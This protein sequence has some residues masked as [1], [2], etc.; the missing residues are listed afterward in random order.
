MQLT[1]RFLYWLTIMIAVG[2]LARL[3]LRASQSPV[4]AAQGGGLLSFVNSGQALGDVQSTD[5]ALGDLDGDG[6]L[7]AYVAVAGTDVLWLNNGDGVFSADDQ[8][9]SS[10]PGLSAVA[11]GDLDSDGDLDVFVG[12]YGHNEVWLNDGAGGLTDSGQRLGSEGSNGV[13]LGDVDDDG[14]LDAVAANG[15]ASSPANRLWLNDGGAQGGSEG[16]FSDSGQLLGAGWSNGVA[17]GD[18][19][20]DGDLDIYFAR[21]GFDEVWLN[22]GTGQFTADPQPLPSGTSIDVALGDLDGDDDLDVWVATS[23]GASQVWLNDGGA[24]GGSEGN[25]SNSGQGLGANRAVAL[26]DLEQDGDLDAVTV[27]SISPDSFDAWLNDGQGLFALEQSE[28]NNYSGL[29]IGNLDGQGGPDLFLIKNGPD[30]VWL[31][32]TPVTPQA[33]VSISLGPTVYCEVPC[34][35]DPFLVTVQNAGPNAATAVTAF[36]KHGNFSSASGP[37]THHFGTLAPGSNVTEPLQPETYLSFPHHYGPLLANAVAH[38]EVTAN[39][40]DPDP[41]NNR[42][43]SNHVSFNCDEFKACSLIKIFCRGYSEPLSNL[44]TF[45]TPSAVFA[46]SL[47]QPPIDL[48]VYYYVRDRVLGHTADGQHYIDLYYSHDPEI[49]AILDG[50]SSLK[51]EAVATL[52]LWQDNLWALVRGN[53][54]TATITAEQVDAV[55]SFLSNLSAAASPALQQTIAVERARLGSPE[56]YIGMTMEEATAAIVGYSVHLPLVKRD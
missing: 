49:Q 10:D 56:E 54:H 12:V 28:G 53:G 30:Q 38:V 5:V 19:D 45:L 26:A 3:T 52:Q 27:R 21:T 48:L 39:E 44:P 24:Q 7:D 43:I 18:V 8:A 25:L 50:S 11:L 46:Q 40:R 29:A 37:T 15:D 14:D 32:H 42:A 23:S 55:D 17:L 47:E 33:D 41:D 31:N 4:R 1:K 6:D 20:G 34:D 2:G 22:D 13:A 51:T 9:L 36:A 16:V 35:V